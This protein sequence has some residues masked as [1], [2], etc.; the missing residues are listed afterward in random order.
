MPPQTTRPPLRTARKRDG[1]ERADGSEQDRRVERL[2]RRLVG[3]ARPGRAEAA[4]EALRRLVAWPRERQDL[5]PLM[6]ADLRDDVRRRAEA[7][8]ADPLARPRRLQAAPADQSGAEQRRGGDR[9]A[10]RRQL[11]RE[12]GLG[13]EVRGVAAVAGVAGEL[14]MVAKILAALVAI[15]AMAAG[16]RQPG[17]ADPLADGEILDPGA[18]PLDQAD[19]LVAGNDRQP[20]IGQLAVDDVQIGAADAAGF[21]ANQ[22]L[23]P[24]RAPASPSLRRRAA[25]RSHATSSRAS[26]RRLVGHQDGHG[27]L[28]HQIDADAAEQ[29]LEQAGVAEGAGDDEVGVLRVEAGEQGFQ[30]RNV[31]GVG[32]VG[33]L[34]DDAVALEVIGQQRPRPSAARSA[35][36]EKVKIVTFLALTSSGIAS[37]TARVASRLAFQAMTMFSPTGA[38]LQSCGRISIGAPAAMQRLVRDLGPDQRAR[39]ALG[40]RAR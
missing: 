9:V 27:R 33:N 15:E 28:A 29:A 24:A 36:A 3:A 5:A 13:D 2:W 31:A 11:Q 38:G 37:W 14:G 25:R 26:P 16:V 17:N 12:R 32:P 6:A 40:A 7:V 8:K 19:H 21:D 10:R 39:L 18:E 1:H 35:R 20:R 30:R 34:G 4:R 23:A 22:Q